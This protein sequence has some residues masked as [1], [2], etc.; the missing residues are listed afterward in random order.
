MSFSHLSAKT[1]PVYRRI[2]Y[3]YS[4]LSAI[5]I[6]PERSGKCKKVNENNLKILRKIQTIPIAAIKMFEKQ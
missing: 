3:S 1:I 6:R 4:K 2:T 5:A